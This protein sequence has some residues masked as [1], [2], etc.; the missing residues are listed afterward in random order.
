MRMVK[1]YLFSCNIFHKNQSLLYLVII[2]LP[3]IHRFLFFMNI[4]FVE[5]TLINNI[6]ILEII[7]RTNKAKDKIIN[8]DIDLDDKI[9]L[10]IYLNK[11]IMI[12]NFF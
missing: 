2:E 11:K 10:E 7:H 4:S 6:K 1:I 9:I 8:N 12:K 5:I 3:L